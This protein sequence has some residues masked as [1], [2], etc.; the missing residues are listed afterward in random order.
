MGPGVQSLKW[1][2]EFTG[3]NKILEFIIY[4]YVTITDGHVTIFQIRLQT[5]IKLVSQAKYPSI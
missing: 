4:I 3:P 1:K 5:L 2:F